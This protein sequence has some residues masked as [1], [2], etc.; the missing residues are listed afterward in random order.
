MIS[1]AKSMLDVAELRSYV[2]DYEKVTHRPPF[3][4]HTIIVIAFLI[5]GE[6]MPQPSY[7]FTEILAVICN[8]F[9]YVLQ[10]VLEEVHQS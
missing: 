5:A 7:N 8:T 1:K 10:C 3:S 9:L 2:A 4:E 6:F